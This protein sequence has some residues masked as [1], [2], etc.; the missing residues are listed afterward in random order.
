MYVA[1][2]VAFSV[3]NIFLQIVDYWECFHQVKHLEPGLF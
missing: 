3:R 1:M 2:E